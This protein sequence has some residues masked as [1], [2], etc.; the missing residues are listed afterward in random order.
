MKNPD[1]PDYVVAVVGCGAMGQG[2]AQVSAQGGMRTLLFDAREGGAA[3]AK[4]QIA[5]RIER[6]VEKGRLGE[7]DAKAAI[8][9]LEP[10]RIRLLIPRV[11]FFWRKSRLIFACRIEAPTSPKLTHERRHSNLVSHRKRR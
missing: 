8:D 1:Q 3:A 9:R 6:L 2:I 10:A 7:S 4:D 11:F 5:K